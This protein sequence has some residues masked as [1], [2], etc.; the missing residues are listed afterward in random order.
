M[1][2]DRPRVPESCGDGAVTRLLLFFWERVKKTD[3]CWLWTGRFD[4]PGYG[5]IQI[6]RD[7]MRMGAHRISWEIHNQACILPGYFACHSCDNP[8]C[9]N[10]D[11]IFLGTQKDNLADASAKGRLSVPNKGWERDLTHCSN[12]HEYTALNTY[13]WGN[14][15]ICRTCRAEHERNRRLKIAGQQKAAA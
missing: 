7:G 8:P 4:G 2:P 3:D 6:G 5:V 11:H 15:R 13:R 1:R 10:P 12:G 9:V 14:K